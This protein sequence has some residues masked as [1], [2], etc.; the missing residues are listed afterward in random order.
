MV[1]VLVDLPLIVV[2]LVVLPQM[3][4]VLHMVLPQTFVMVVVLHMV[5]P[6]TFVMVEVLLVVLEGSLLE[7]VHCLLAASV[8]RF[9]ELYCTTMDLASATLLSWMTPHLISLNNS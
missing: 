7:L 2:L 6:Q 9:G 1:G 4:V 3:V 8:V 5:L